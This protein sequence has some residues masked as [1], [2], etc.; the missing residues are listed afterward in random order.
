M[1]LVRHVRR[2]DLLRRLNQAQTLLLCQQKMR[3]RKGHQC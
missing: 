2:A 3:E 1:H